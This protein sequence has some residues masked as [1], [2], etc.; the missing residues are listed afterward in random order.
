MYIIFSADACGVLGNSELFSMG[1]VDV[2]DHHSQKAIW[3][4]GLIKKDHNESR[5][6]F[7]LWE[8]E[9]HLADVIQHVRDTTFAIAT[10]PGSSEN[11]QL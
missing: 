8:E 5:G 3:H 2:R 11:C 6:L 9:M 10:G 7:E 1:L 4:L